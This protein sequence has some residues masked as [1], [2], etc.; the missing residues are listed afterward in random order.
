MKLQGLRELEE[1]L[2][3]LGAEVGGKVLA[4]AARKAFAPVVEIAKARVPVDTG[5]LHE[6]IRLTV[7]KPK[8]EGAAVVAGMRIAGRTARHGGGGDPSVYWRYVEMGTAKK[9]ARPF[10]RPALDANAGAVVETLRTELAAGI[11]R[12]IKRTRK[13]GRK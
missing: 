6:S 8:G 13:R 9:A 7:S 5:A 1:Q 2:L 10:A 11:E 4:R 12:A 3:K